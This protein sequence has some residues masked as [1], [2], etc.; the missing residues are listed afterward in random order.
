MYLSV[1][2]VNSILQEDAAQVENPGE[3]E[4]RAGRDAPRRRSQLEEVRPEGHLGRQVPEVS[5]A[6]FTFFSVRDR[7]SAHER[8]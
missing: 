3:G 5:A 4:L 7:V 6:P 2:S 8:R 1:I